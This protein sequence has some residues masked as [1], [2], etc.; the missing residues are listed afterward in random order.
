M[1]ELPQV[2]NIEATLEGHPPRTNFNVIR[3]DD[4]YN[5]RIAQVTGQFPWHRHL[6]GDEGWLIWK[7]RLRIDFEGGDYVEL[8]P[9]DFTKV[10]VGVRHSPTCVEDG[11]IVV[12]FNIKDFQ[13]EFV[14]VDPE[15]GDFV[16]HD[17]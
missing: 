9:G 11:T 8:G 4:S 10:P 2:F 15:V 3:L 6:N 13:H 1:T 5:V 16:E 7:G 12:V 14:D 17:V